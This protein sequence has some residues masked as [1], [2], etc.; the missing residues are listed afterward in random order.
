[1]RLYLG[2]DSMTARCNETAKVEIYYLPD[3]DL[4]K[5]DKMML[6]LLQ[7]RAPSYLALSP[8]SLQEVSGVIEK[9]HEGVQQREGVLDAYWLI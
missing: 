1:M 8:L 4:I 3:Y 7:Q 2:L 5:L 6:I 9:L